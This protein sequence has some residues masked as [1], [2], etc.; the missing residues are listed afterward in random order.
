VWDTGAAGG[1]EAD[2]ARLT[3]LI[4]SMRQTLFEDRSAYLADSSVSIE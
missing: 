1:Q 4:A 3:Q 2:I